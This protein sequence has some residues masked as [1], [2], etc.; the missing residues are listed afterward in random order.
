MTVEIFVTL[1]EKLFARV[2][3]PSEDP[4]VC[5]PWTGATTSKGYGNI[6]WH[7]KNFPTHVVAFDECVDDIPKGM[8][9]CHSCDNP[10]CCRPSHLFL[11][12]AQ[13]NTDDMMIKGRHVSMSGENHGGAILIELEVREIFHLAWQ[14]DFTLQA[15]GNRFG[16]SRT[17][18]RYIKYGQSWA[19]L[20]LRRW[21]APQI[22][23]LSR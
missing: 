3:R 11:G 4:Q 20:N 5:W 15:I 18:V 16:V 22:V 6:W 23:E 9:V 10:P 2:N 19:H 14:G 17:L 12:N 21:H 7:G 8:M 13:D 1:F